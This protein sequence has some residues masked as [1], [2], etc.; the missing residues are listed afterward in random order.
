MRQDPKFGKLVPT[1]SGMAKTAVE[2]AAVGCTHSRW[3]SSRIGPDGRSEDTTDPESG[4]SPTRARAGSPTPA[5]GVSTSALWLIC[6]FGLRMKKQ[7]SYL[8]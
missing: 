5:A 6:N 7:E 3:K 4:L 1:A 8:R 2:A